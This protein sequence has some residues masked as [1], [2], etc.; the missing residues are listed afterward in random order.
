MEYVCDYSWWYVVKVFT[1]LLF[2]IFLFYLY[3]IVGVLLYMIAW[4]GPEND[5]EFANTFA[6]CKYVLIYD[7]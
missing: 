7:W 3:M 5:V 1:E 4:S 6:N 2:V